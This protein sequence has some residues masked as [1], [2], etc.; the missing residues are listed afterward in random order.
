MQSAILLDIVDLFG[1]AQQGEQKQ[2]Q[3]H[4]LAS[5]GCAFSLPLPSKPPHSSLKNSAKGKM[6]IIMSV[7]E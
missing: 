3:R 4:W 7:R 2:I 1:L 5:E 6:E